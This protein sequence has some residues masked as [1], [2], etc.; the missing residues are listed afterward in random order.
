M[1][2]HVQAVSEPAALVAGDRAVLHDLVF[3]EYCLAGQTMTLA[4]EVLTWCPW[5]PA[6]T[7]QARALVR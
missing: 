1:R 2:A 3:D 7:A 4:T 6:A 5:W